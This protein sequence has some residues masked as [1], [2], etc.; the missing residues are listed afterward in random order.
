[1]NCP[2]IKTTR[3]KFINLSK[4]INGC[5][6]S[7]ILAW[8]FRIPKWVNKQFTTCCNR[9]D[10]YYMYQMPKDLADDILY[11]CWYEEAYQHKGL[12]RK[13][14]CKLAD[15]GYWCLNTKLSEMCYEAGK[16]K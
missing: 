2:K 4:R 7:F 6:S 3:K 16:R 9:H 8:P 15:F 5:G 13:L 11:N 10:L 12:K 1:M 14:L